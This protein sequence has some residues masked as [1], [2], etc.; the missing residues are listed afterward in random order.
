M[1]VAVNVFVYIYERVCKSVCS[2]YV[3][4]CE[5]SLHMLIYVQTLICI[6]LDL[7]GF[8]SAYIPVC[9]S[10][11]REMRERTDICGTKPTILSNTE[12]Y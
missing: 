10:Q 1:S 12:R 5:V 3:V 2:R 7:N 6:S 11:S 9:I 4:M 8:I